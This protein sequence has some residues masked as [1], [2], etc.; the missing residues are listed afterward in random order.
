MGIRDW[1][2][3]TDDC[4][5]AV[6]CSD[7]LKPVAK[8]SLHWRMKPP[9]ATSPARQTRGHYVERALPDKSRTVCA[10][11]KLERMVGNAGTPCVPL[12]GDIT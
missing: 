4:C 12:T 10:H 1:G 3:G 5:L 7:Q 9:V 8:P 2:T 6:G 11:R